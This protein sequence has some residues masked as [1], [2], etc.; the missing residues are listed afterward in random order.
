MHPS[1]PARALLY[2]ALLAALLATKES[3]QNAGRAQTEGSERLQVV[4]RGP[5]SGRRCKSGATA[6]VAVLKDGVGVISP[7]LCLH[8]SNSDH[9][10]DDFQPCCTVTWHGGSSSSEL[11]GQAHLP[12]WRRLLSEAQPSTSNSS[13]NPDE[14]PAAEKEDEWV[15]SLSQLEQLPAWAT[16][17]ADHS[18]TAMSDGDCPGCNPG[19]CSSTAQG[20]VCSACAGSLFVSRADGSCGKCWLLT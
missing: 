2:C 18:V 6:A 15:Q 8:T 3:V 5:W 10:T 17:R 20:F 1:G 12:G 9:S 14:D 7:A 19:A 13:S 11:A 16:A 4:T